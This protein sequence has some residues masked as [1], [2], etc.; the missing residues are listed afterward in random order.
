MPPQAAKNRLEDCRPGSNNDEQTANGEIDIEGAVNALLREQLVVGDTTNTPAECSGSQMTQGGQQN[1]RFDTKKL[2]EKI[3][4]IEVEERL[5]GEPHSPQTRGQ[6]SRRV[7][8][9]PSLSHPT[10]HKGRHRI[11]RG[12]KVWS[13]GG[14]RNG[15]C[16]R[17]S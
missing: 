17:E 12:R 1:M 8:P 4:E 5:D 10:S 13:K 11:I 6:G 16:V 2:L 7:H 9:F 3:L 15:V 14:W